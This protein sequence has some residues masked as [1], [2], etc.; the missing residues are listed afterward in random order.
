[1]DES[2]KFVPKQFSP[3]N[4]S[5]VR[6]IENFWVW[7]GQKI[8]K[9][10]WEA[11]TRQQLIRHVESMLKEFDTHVIDTHFVESLLEGVKAKV[12][13]IGDNNVYALF[14]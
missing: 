1:M 11:K 8:Y 12:R 5:H 10:N 9:G 7:L 3:Q 14:K 6:P 13:S 4:V 2:V